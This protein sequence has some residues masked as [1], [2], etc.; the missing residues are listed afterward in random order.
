MRGK[1]KKRINR[2]I[3]RQGK[4]ARISVRKRK[5]GVRMKRKRWV[6]MTG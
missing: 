2:E 5:S 4:N 3:T 6:C 1:R